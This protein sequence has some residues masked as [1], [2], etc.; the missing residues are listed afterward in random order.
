[1]LTPASSATSLAAVL[2]PSLL[3]IAL[4]GPIKIILFFSHNSAKSGFSDK[5]PYPGCIASTPAFFAISIIEL[6]SK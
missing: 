6:I 1:M 2:L 5:K 4:F 3:S